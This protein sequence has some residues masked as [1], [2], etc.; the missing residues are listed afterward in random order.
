M[1][2]ARGPAA[3]LFIGLTFAGCEVG[4]VEFRPPVEE[5][6][7]AVEGA[8]LY[9]KTVGVGEPIVVV[10]GG[11]GFEHSYLLPGLEPLG[12]TFR[13]V[14]YDQRGL[15]RSTGDL[16]PT[17]ISMERYI[18]DLDAMREMAGV[19]RVNI[20]AHSWGSLI[21]MMYALEHPDRLNALILMSPVE[22]GRRYAVEAQANQQ[23]R[24]SPED[25]AA[26]DSLV[27]SPGFERGE[28]ETLGWILHHM[29]RG[30][31]ADPADADALRLVF[32]ERTA[33]QRRRVSELLMEPLAELDLWDRLAEVTV[34]VLIVHGDQDPSPVS[35]VTEMSERLPNARLE[36]LGD[37]GHFPFVEAPG[38]LFGV[39]QRFLE[40]ERPGGGAPD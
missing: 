29:L 7:R 37:V 9:Y 15:G 16:D 40:E 30:T 14:L 13:V 18:A 32:T 33:E 26:I 6:T 24:R 22:P 21:A 5:G 35:M 12:Q 28:P 23:A 31:L 8:E 27:R 4:Q 1:I 17:S 3:G 19:E 25:A 36:V 10:H 11:P 2:R 38:P 20:L 39:I 34:P